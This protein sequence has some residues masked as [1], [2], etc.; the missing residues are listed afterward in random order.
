MEEGNVILSWSGNRKHGFKVWVRDHPDIVVMIRT[1]EDDYESPIASACIEHLNVM[2]PVFVFENDPPV[3]RR[4]RS[5]CEPAWFQVSAGID[6]ISF[7]DFTII[8]NDGVDTY[9]MVRQVVETLFEGGL[10]KHCATPLGPRTTVP[11]PRLVFPGPVDGQFYSRGHYW[12]NPM[13]ISTAVADL[14]RP[15]IDDWYEF[16]PLEQPLQLPWYK[17]RGSQK[18][19]FLEMIPRKWVDMVGLRKP[20]C[21]TQF[22]LGCSARWHTYVAMQMDVECF[23]SRDS[24]QKLTGPVACGRWGTSSYHLLV[25]DEIRRKFLK[26]RSAHGFQ[27]ARLAFAPAEEIAQQ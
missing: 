2:S 13:I 19:R 15:G 1:F 25:A 6:D 14:L 12:N 5:W 18:R 11:L 9:P 8:A 3:T 27:F 16:R 20:A 26:N 17:Q 21:S 22:C 4:F 23:T 7:Y 24:L 10:C